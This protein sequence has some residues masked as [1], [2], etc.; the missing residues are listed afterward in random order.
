MLISGMLPCLFLPTCR[1][2]FYDRAQYR[3]RAF[4]NR[5]LLPTIAL[6]FLYSLSPVLHRR[7]DFS[8]T[9]SRDRQK[10]V[11]D[12]AKKSYTVM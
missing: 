9:N 6:R 8:E 1:F 11:A 4:G 10:Q 2:L 12:S 7:R 3:P 5:L